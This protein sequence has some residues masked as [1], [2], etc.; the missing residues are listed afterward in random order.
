[1]HTLLANPERGDWID[2]GLVEKVIHARKV[3]ARRGVPERNRTAGSA[4]LTGA[5]GIAN[6]LLELVHRD[7]MLFDV[8]FIVYIPDEE[9]VR[10][11][12]ATLFS[13]IVTGVDWHR[14]VV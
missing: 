2:G 10:H 4:A 8:S 6:D 12:D 3:L 9:V 1:M 7:A 14:H 5:V 13:Y 11:R